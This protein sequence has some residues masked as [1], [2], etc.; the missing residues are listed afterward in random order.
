MKH[1][2]QSCRLYGIVDMGYTAPGQVAEKTSALLAGGV[3]LVLSGTF[4]QSGGPALT[5]MT[6]VGIAMMA[7]AVALHVYARRLSG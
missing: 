7:L 3:L 2:L 1:V 6:V 4:V 5:P